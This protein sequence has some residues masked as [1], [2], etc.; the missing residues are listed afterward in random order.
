MFLSIFLVSASDTSSIFG[1]NSTT[2]KE[3]K[4]TKIHPTVAKIT[5]S[6]DEN[7]N[8]VVNCPDLWIFRNAFFFAGVV[9]TTIGYGDI[10]PVTL[11]EYLAAICFMIGAGALFSYMLASLSSIMEVDAQMREYMN[12]MVQ[13]QSEIEKYEDENE[14]EEGAIDPHEM[15]RK[16]TTIH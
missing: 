6:L 10:Y 11:T 8:L 13:M 14:D 12:A 16:K 2:T 3:K 4:H 5:T 1:G 9:G 15:L 7:G